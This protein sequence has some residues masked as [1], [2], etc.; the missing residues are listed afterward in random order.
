MENAEFIVGDVEDELPKLIKE[1]N[2]KPDVVF[3]DPPRKGCDK[4]AIE[5]LL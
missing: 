5:T 4:V 1:K 3:I 2:I